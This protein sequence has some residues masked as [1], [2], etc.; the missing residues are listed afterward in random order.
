MGKKSRLKKERRI[1]SIPP[2]G[3]YVLNAKSHQEAPDADFTN[4]ISKLKELF[5]RYRAEDVC[6]S[7]IISDLWLP[8]ISS[9]VKHHFAYGVLLSISPNE[10]KEELS[11][12]SYEAYRDFLKKV[13]L[14][15]PRFY[16]LEDYIPEPDWG[17]IKIL[18]RG[19]FLR[20][21]Y[22]GSIERIY[23]FIEAFKL[24]YL[25]SKK[26]KTVAAKNA[27]QDLHTVAKLQD[28]LIS[29]IDKSIGKVDDISPG[30][31]E[32]P[33]A[34]F[35]EQ[36][37]A[38]LLNI[39][40]SFTD[41][42]CSPEIIVP[43]GKHEIPESE[44]EFSDSLFSGASVP[45]I[46]V[47]I[48]NKHFPISPRNA[49]G[50]VLEYWE[51]LTKD[52]EFE[53]EVLAENIGT[54]LGQ[55]F[56]S[57]ELIVGP[58]KLASLKKRTDNTFAAVILAE[59]K[60]YFLIILS[61]VDIEQLPKI[62]KDVVEITSGIESWGLFHQSYHGAL[63]L[64]VSP[65]DLEIIVLVPAV[66]AQFCSITP[67]DETKARICFLPDFVT[68]MDS[69]N[70]AK[71]FES[72]WAFVDESDDKFGPMLGLTDIFASFRDSHSVL[73]D[74]AFSPN[75]IVLDPH[76]GSNWRFDE[77]VKF[78]NVAPNLFP[79]DTNIAWKIDP[80]ISGIQQLI[81]KGFPILAQH[82]PVGGCT[83][84]F[85]FEVS[86]DNALDVESGKILELFVHCIADSLAQR[87][88]LFSNLPLFN[89][90]RI[91]TKCSANTDLLPTESDK[92]SKANLAMPLFS[93]WRIISN[94][95][96]CLE[97]TVD[98]NLSAVRTKLTDAIDASFEVDCL[99]DWLKELSELINQDFNLE[100]M[101][102]IYGTKNYKPRFKLSCEKRLVDVPDY[103]HPEIPAPV[104]YKLARRDLAFLF[105]KIGKEPGK[106]ELKEA[107]Y[108]IDQV[109]D[110]ARL[111]IHRRIVAFDKEALIVFCIQQYDKLIAYYSRES[112]RVKLSMSHDVD[113]DRPER[114]VELHDEFIKNARNYRY[115]LECCLSAKNSGTEPVATKIV[116]SL[117]AQV[118][119]LLVLYGASD[120]LHNDIDVAG[121]I[122]DN[123]FV[124]E[125][126]Y[127]E[128]RKEQE[129]I[130]GLELANARLGKGLN[131][132]DEVN[133]TES[134]RLD[135]DKLDKA[136]LK[137]VGFKFKHFSETLVVL[138]QWKRIRSESDLS[139]SYQASKQEIIKTVL[140]AMP[141]IPQIEVE[142]IIDFA[143]LNPTQVRR[144]IGKNVDESDV[145]IWEYNKRESR[146]T[147]KP[148][149][150]INELLNWGAGS[151]DRA[152]RNWYVSISNGYLPAD[153]PWPNVKKIVRDIKNSI[154]KKLEVKAHE[155][156]LKETSYAISG[157]D[158]KY[159]FPVEKFDDVGDYDVLAYWP[160]KNIWL[161]IECKYNQPP[162]CLK[163]GRRLRER[164]FGIGDD[165][166]QF[167]KIEGR[168]KFLATNLD[169]L[170]SLLGWPSPL[171][172]SPS[173]I[174][175]LYVSRDIYWWMRNPPYKVP[176]V[177]VRI[178]ALKTWL[179]KH[180]DSL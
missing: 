139:F 124:P 117:I 91:V 145:P 23:D 19:E 39:S 69:L 101:A 133:F 158:F 159:Q 136:F 125:I 63:Q 65:D 44:S 149:I 9:T 18:S 37:K 116:V 144:L 142:K 62:E 13:Y 30:H 114:L 118:D 84:F 97:V 54:F 119:W 51:G 163:D 34:K 11:L 75:M 121:V 49:M 71:E 147:T 152:F 41:I 127:S 175:E 42:S 27:E 17:E 179:V 108:L 81:A 103:A 43:L 98:I 100:V 154:E 64:N 165:H 180:I 162:Y 115:L 79:N 68:I 16:M 56:L 92:D 105:Q 3:S 77:L 55:R 130:F 74:G 46:L 128:S 52:Q 93:S 45:G 132:D 60:V 70:N 113:F 177:F 86:V 53:K 96:E 166:G 109:R 88:S 72:F 146:Y 120:V 33:S 20:I 111:L 1:N 48:G 155:I 99:I 110:E 94:V 174:H 87:N 135:W 32:I 173:T 12:D 58:V 35:W 138:S 123:S 24:K 59:T 112:T 126:F 156:C 78:W 66:S 61:D 25:S 73:V 10:F 169:R 102:K 122:L 178:D 160:K 176:T 143:T 36:S 168:R 21:F 170:R 31:I 171:N 29:Q 15:L 141:E 95:N 6:V 161:T 107:K 22:G 38:A 172:T 137:D 106:Y 129:R 140:M 26:T 90:R 134:S 8:N 151:V 104:N 148:L 89:F 131:A 4:R 150:P 167:S 76:W 14:T 40:L 28:L 83:V 67:P 85:S 153:F 82:V 164:I 80:K 47:R 7:L 157:I 2:S 50:V 57:R 5:S